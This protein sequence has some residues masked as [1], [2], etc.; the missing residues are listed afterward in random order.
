MIANARSGGGHAADI[1]AR[2]SEAL[3]RRDHQVQQRLVDDIRR[4][5]AQ[6]V[7]AACG[8]TCL[9][10]IGGDETLSE[11]ARVAHDARVP[12]LPVP[13]GFGNI[14]AATFGWR[15]T[16][17]AVLETVERGRVQAIDA[18]LFDD[19]FFLCSQAFGFLEVA[20][21]AVETSGRQP[22]QRWRRYG[23][24]VHA[25]VESMIR[26]PLPMLGVQIDGRLLTARASTV[27]VA[28]VPT[29]RTF[30]PIVTDANPCDGLLDVVVPTALSKWSLVAWLLSTLVRAP[31]S[32]RNALS[33][34][35]SRVTITDGV[36]ESEIRVVPRSVPVLLPG[37]GGRGRPPTRRAG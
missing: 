7:Q 16:V 1:G 32:R 15:A 30:L 4:V 8:V 14:F 20:R 27:I 12:L 23:S 10:G 19:S 29:Y 34:R 21:L 9:V 33:R 35:A 31:G 5:R 28:N 25:A 2:L 13:A 11:L 18:G 3:R 17:A 6:L 37:D 22:R 36:T 26:T 24:Y